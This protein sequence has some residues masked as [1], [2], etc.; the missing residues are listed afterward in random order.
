MKISFIAPGEITIPPNG[1]GALETVVWHQSQSLRDLG[2]NIQI[3][4]EPEPQKAYEQIAKFNPDIV[5]LHYGKHYEILPHINARKIVTNHNGSFINNLKFHEAII[6]EFM[7]DCEFFNLTTWECDLLKTIGFPP[8]NIKILPNGVDYNSFRKSEKPKHKDRS[9]CLGKI[10]K[11]KRQAFLQDLDAQIDF[12]GQNSDIDFN[13]LHTNFLGPWTRDQVYNHLTE[14]SNLILLSESE[15][16][17]L[18]CLE[19][20]SAG[21]GLVLTEACTQNLDTSL[22]FISVIPN[23]KNTDKAYIKHTIIENRKYCNYIDRQEIL[24][25]A[26]KFDWH[27]IAIKYQEYIV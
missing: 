18:V 3:V 7:Y 26:A 14:Y 9:I 24:Q 13:P 6:R 21:L 22:P 11:R 10:D 25:Y 15:L 23:D 1:W 17:P 16:Q 4:N 2:Y 20:L 27:N 5:H 19:A 8:K 12:V